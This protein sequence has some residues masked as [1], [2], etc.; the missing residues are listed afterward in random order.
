MKKLSHSQAIKP[1][2]A[3]LR[4]SGNC[5]FGQDLLDILDSI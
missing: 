3:D 5:Y 2:L 1:N 4:R